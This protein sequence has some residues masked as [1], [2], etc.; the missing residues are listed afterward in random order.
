M[1]LVPLKY[2]GHIRLDTTYHVLLKVC[3]NA[4]TRND[5]SQSMKLMS[6]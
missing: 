4:L 1:A 5:T 2:S 3:E 6:C